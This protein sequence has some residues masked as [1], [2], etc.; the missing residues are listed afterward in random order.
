MSRSPM[1]IVS[2][3][4][5][6]VTFGRVSTRAEFVALLRRLEDQFRTDARRPL[7]HIE[8]HGADDGIGNSEADGMSWTELADE[9]V[10]FSRLTRLNLVV[11][12]AACH[13]AWGM[14]ML[15]PDRRAAAFRGLIG[16]D[17]DMDDFEVLD[18]SLAFYRGIFR[19]G[20]G[21]IAF[22]AMNEAF[23]HG[24]R[25]HMWSAEIAFEIVYRHYLATR[26]SPEDVGKRSA[27]IAARVAARVKRARGL[28]RF[29]WEIERDTKAAGAWL[30]DHEARFAEL[31]RDF[32]FIN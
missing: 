19:R 11:V 32:F 1:G 5:V 18:A 31:R 23:A 10:G 6:P 25:F 13:G 20:D 15:H 26:C 27:A 30:G 8:A 14:K 16:P 3:P 4:Q 2:K 24:K 7:L 9:L 29:K 22:T 12:L 28:G 21:N 17:Q